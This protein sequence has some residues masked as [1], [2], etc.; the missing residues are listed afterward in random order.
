MD[1]LAYLAASKFLEISFGLKFLIWGELC[2][3]RV[4]MRK[5]ES[6]EVTESPFVFVCGVLILSNSELP[7]FASDFG[8]VIDS[9]TE[10]CVSTLPS[11]CSNDTS[12]FLKLDF[13]YQKLQI[14]TNS[15]FPL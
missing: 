5:A 7:L 10:I 12:A 8:Y 4:L 13:K 3:F 11:R 15:V 9:E 2:F 1:S 6:Q 14:S